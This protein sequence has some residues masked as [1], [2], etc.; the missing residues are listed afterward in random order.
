MAS[1]RKGDVVRACRAAVWPPDRSSIKAWRPT[2]TAEREAWYEQNRKDIAA[3]KE[4]PFDET[5]E[6]WLAPEY[7][8][9]TIPAGTVLLVIRG[10]ARG[11]LDRWRAQPCTQVLWSEMGET[12]FVSRDD[13]ELAW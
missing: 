10:R 6:P 13:I 2:T 7:A 4:E 9:F 1:F 11:F 8:T 5:G 12:L 3:G